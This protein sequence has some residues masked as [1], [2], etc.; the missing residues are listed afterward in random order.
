VR[1]VDRLKDVIKSGGEWVSSLDPEAKLR[2]HRAVAEVAVVGVS[3]PKWG[4]RP[5]DPVRL[6]QILN[7]FVSNAIKFTPEGSI[8]ISAQWVGRADGQESLLFVVKDTGIGI[9]QED[10]QRLFQPFSQAGDV[11]RRRAGGAGLGLVISHRPG[12]GGRNAGAA[13]G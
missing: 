3:D 2:E 4:E 1:I 12:R 9:S 8:E 13:G 10:Q 7:N 5:C 6:R 11:V